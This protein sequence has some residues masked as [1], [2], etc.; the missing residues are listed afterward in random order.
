MPCFLGNREPEFFIGGTRIREMYIGNRQVYQYDSVAPSLTVEAPMGT[1]S[2]SPTYTTS[3]TY[4]VSG[5]VGDADSGVDAVYVNGSPATISGSSWSTS[6]SLS[7]DTSKKIEVY[8]VDRAGNKTDTITRYVQYDSGAPTLTV[9]APTGTSSSSP[10]Y[11][12]SDSAYSYTVSGTVS[13]ASGIKSITVNGQEATIS[14][15]SWSKTLSLATNT[16][17]TITVV[18]TD[19]AGR[20]TTVNRYLHIY[21][22]VHYFINSARA[23]GVSTSVSYS[24]REDDSYISASGNTIKTYAGND[25]DNARWVK[26]YTAF[27]PS[28]KGCG[29]KITVVV[30]NVSIVNGEHPASLQQQAILYIRNT[31]TGARTSL[32]SILGKNTYTFSVPKDGATY[33]LDLYTQLH[34]YTLASDASC[35][36][37][38]STLNVK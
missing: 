32:G 19:N 29:Q 4:T 25:A 28:F 35:T 12:Q 15:N 2:G 3:D 30:T 18:A 24:T 10:T 37:T 1:S 27:S 33:T 21:A 36:L 6:I 23:S 17:H 14:G 5:T 22:S 26:G 9:T 7:K 13:D 11:V 20:T 8:A 31:A 38:F 16:T 34:S